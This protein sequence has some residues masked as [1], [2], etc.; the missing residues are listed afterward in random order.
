[1]RGRVDAQ[2]HAREDEKLSRKLA[3]YENKQPW[4]LD[5]ASRH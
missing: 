4:V 2:F 1:M 5:L 3:L